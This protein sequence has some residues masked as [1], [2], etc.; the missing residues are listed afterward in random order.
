[1][2]VLAKT[3]QKI[4]LC[5]VVGSFEMGFLHA[6]RVSMICRARLLFSTTKQITTKIT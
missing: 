4:S 3:A 6:P 2:M 5:V 1:M